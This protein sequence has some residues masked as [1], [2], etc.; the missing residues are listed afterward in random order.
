MKPTSDTK[1]IR[2][3]YKKWSKDLTQKFSKEL[4]QKIK[5]RTRVKK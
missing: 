4:I 1:K 3:R 5:Q 2:K